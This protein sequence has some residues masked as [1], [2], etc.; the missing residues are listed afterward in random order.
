MTAARTPFPEE[1]FAALAA[2]E[3]GHWWFRARNRVLL[4]ALVSRV[5]HFDSFLEIGCGTGFVLEGSVK[6]IQKQIFTA[7]NIS[8]KAFCMPERECLLPLFPN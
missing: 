1:T 4:W 6:P 8:K 2:A 3:A 5:G 7:R